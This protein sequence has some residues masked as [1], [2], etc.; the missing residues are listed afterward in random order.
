MKPYCFF[1]V[2]KKIV[3]FIFSK[4]AFPTIGTKQQI[5]NYGQYAASFALVFI[6][7]VDRRMVFIEVRRTLRNP[8]KSPG[9]KSRPDA[10]CW[11]HRPQESGKTLTAFFVGDGSPDHRRMDA[12]TGSGAVH[13]SPEG[14]EQRRARQSEAPPR[15]TKSRIRRFRGG[16]SGHRRANQERRHDAK[17]TKAHAETSPRKS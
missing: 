12:R 16:I 11:R 3:Q 10:M 6:S 8:E 14:P 15:R 5:F 17:R 13:F 7:S 4:Y 2:I 9:R 1:V